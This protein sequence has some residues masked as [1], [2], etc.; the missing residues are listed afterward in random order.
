VV[1]NLCA[2]DPGHWSLGLQKPDAATAA[3][4]AGLSLWVEKSLLLQMPAHAI[5]CVMRLSRALGYM[6]I[7]AAL[8]GELT[9]H[10]LRYLFLLLHVICGG[11][12]CV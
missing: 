1:F 4:E 7:R 6:L 11:A 8:D 12:S 3:G 10:A 2:N 5:G 9:K